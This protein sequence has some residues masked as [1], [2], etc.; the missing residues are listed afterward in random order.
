MKIETKFNQL[1]KEGRKAF[2]AYFPFG[3]PKI[4]Y[5]NDIF[6][7][8]QDAGVDI[9]EL[10]F[11]FSDPLADGPIIQKASVTAL[12]QNISIN[13]FFANIRK[14][15]KEIKIPVVVMSYYNPIFKYKVGSFF[16]RL[17]ENEIRG[18]ILVDLPFEESGNYINAAEKSGIDPIFFI[19]PVTAAKRM[20]KIAKGAKGFIYY[21]STTGITGPRSLQH[22]DIAS[23]IK[24]I[25]EI[26][27][28][29]VCVGFGIHN[30]QQVKKISSISDGVIVGSEIVKFISQ[31]YKKKNFLKRLK[32]HVRKLRS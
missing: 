27:N 23:H 16:Q 6:L 3:F 26:S 4:S 19:T 24:R 1:K 21:I 15:K 30:N 20:K 10:G 25:K 18:T 12:E 5:S 29:P 28:T 31:N 2:I 7:A 8:L 22:K 11:P 13:S 32:N 17:R 9:I 14:I